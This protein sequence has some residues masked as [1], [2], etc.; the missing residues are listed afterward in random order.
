M[1]K[2][3]L[4]V[5]VSFLTVIALPGYA[6]NVCPSFGVDTNCGVIITITDQGA[7]AIPTGQPPYDNIEDTLIGVVNNSKLPISSLFLTSGAGVFGFDGDGIDTYGAPGNPRDTTGYGGPNTYFTNT[8]GVSGVVNFITPIPPGKTDYFSL[9]LSIGSAVACTALINNSVPKPSGGSPTVAATFTPQPVNGV[10]YTVAQAAQLCGF[11]DFDWVQT[12]TR[13]VDPN[14]LSA[15]NIAVAPTTANVG[16]FNIPV[17]LGGKFRPKINGPVKIVAN[18]ASYSDPPQGGGYTYN[19]TPD[20]SYPFY[21]DPTGDITCPRTAT[22]LSMSDVP[23]QTCMVD[24]GGNPSNAYL[25]SAKVRAGCGNMNAKIGASKQFI[26]HLAGIK[27][28]GTPFDLGIGFTWTSDYN[29][30]AGGVAVSG[31]SSLPP[32]PGSGTGGVTITSYNGITDYQYGGISVGGINGVSQSQTL[33]DSSQVTTTA[34]GLAFS[35]V[36]QTF[37]G[38]ASITNVSGNSLS[39]P[40]QLVLA[41]LPANVRLTNATNTFGGFPYITLP[42]A[43]TLAPGQTATVALE[44]ANPSKASITF[45]P[46]IYAGSLEQ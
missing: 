35:R 37:N 46:L 26:T 29:G 9:E 41:S 43:S 15:S 19:T 10:Q 8:Q 25:S 44:F 27:L 33:L 11:A 12:I 23:T 20:Y 1:L 13:E 22:T 14:R 32:D 40:F 34:S 2:Q 31:K 16:G 30:T 24:A 42:G 38:T 36:T 21:C 18:M 4:L 39:G 17:H 3:R 7:K 45:S 28:D 5:I 6:Q